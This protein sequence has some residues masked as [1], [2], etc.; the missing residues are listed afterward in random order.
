MKASFPI[1]ANLREIFVGK[2]VKNKKHKSQKLGLFFK[3]H[4]NHP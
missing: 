3:N 4:N 1:C 2:E